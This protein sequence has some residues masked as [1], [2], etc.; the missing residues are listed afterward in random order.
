MLNCNKRCKTI[1]NFLSP[2]LSIVNM[3]TVQEEDLGNGFGYENWIWSDKKGVFN[4]EKF[5]IENLDI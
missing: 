5:L 3:T 4:K 2:D 1:G